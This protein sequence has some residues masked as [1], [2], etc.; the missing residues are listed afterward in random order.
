[1][2]QGILLELCVMSARA[3]SRNSIRTFTEFFILPVQALRS[4]KMRHS[5]D[6]MQL[7]KARGSLATW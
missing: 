5:A 1:M 2:I 4:R 3:K 7:A 6:K